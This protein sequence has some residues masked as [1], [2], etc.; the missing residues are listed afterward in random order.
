MKTYN[1]R[2]KNFFSA[3]NLVSYRC[4]F[5]AVNPESLESV[6][7]RF[8]VMKRVKNAIG[9][10][11]YLTCPTDEVILLFMLLKRKLVAVSTMLK[12]Y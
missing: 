1:I 3:Y 9:G 2:L 6:F 8:L 10:D 12:K 5:Q 4:R 7:E 11:N